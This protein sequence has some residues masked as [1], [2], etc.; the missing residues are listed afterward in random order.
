[1]FFQLESTSTM[2]CCENKHTILMNSIWLI[3]DPTQHMLRILAICLRG[4]LLLPKCQRCFYLWILTN[5]QQLFSYLKILT[6]GL[7]TPQYNPHMGPMGPMVMSRRCLHV[8]K[9]TTQHKS[10][11]KADGK[12]QPPNDNNTWL[13]SLIT[14]VRRISFYF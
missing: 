2:L 6:R 14:T 5:Q 10:V 12:A 1:M 8:T 4:K 11:V 9:D 13:I 7:A 3:P